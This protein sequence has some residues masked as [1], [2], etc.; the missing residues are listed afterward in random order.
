MPL[1]A[2]A[3]NLVSPIL[4]V[5]ATSVIRLLYDYALLFIVL[6]FVY[7]YIQSR[8]STKAGRELE[9]RWAR[10]S[11]PSLTNTEDLTPSV[12]DRWAPRSRRQVLSG[13]KTNC[14]APASPKAR[15]LNLKPTP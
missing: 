12:G 3:W 9:C 7:E 2:D 5:V 11:D 4:A 13:W 1:T 8:R 14:G 15:I 10:M 6:A